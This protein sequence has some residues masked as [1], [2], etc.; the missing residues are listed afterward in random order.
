MILTKPLNP[1][2]NDKHV[3]SINLRTFPIDLSQEHI[4]PTPGTL[5][6]TI[7]LRIVNMPVQYV[8]GMTNSNSVVFSTF[9]WFAGRGG[10]PGRA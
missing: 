1:I 6:G 7:A 8:S 10:G 5:K 2:L 9:I 3:C 4:S